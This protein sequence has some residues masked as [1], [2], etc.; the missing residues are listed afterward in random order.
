[1]GRALNGLV[2][3]CLGIGMLAATTAGAQ[4]FGAAKEKVTLERKLPALV[5][6]TGTTIKV[7]VTGHDDQSD[8]ARDL[9]A[10]LETEL[11]KDDPRLTA[12]DRNPSA[13]VTCQ[14]TNYSQP[15][16]TVTTRPSYG[17]SGGAQKSQAYTRVTGALSVSFQA[18]SAGGEMLGSDNVTVNYDQE[19]DSSGNATSQGVKGTVT[20]AWK[21]VVGGTNGEDFNPPTD[22]ELRSHLLDEAVRRIAEHIVN[23]SEMV[24]VY[25]ARQKGALD[26]G[27]K[28][29]EAGL[30]QRALETFETARPLSK[31]AEDA[32]RLYNIGVAYEALAYKAEDE[33]SAMKF[34]DEAA[35]NYG[36][37]IDAK[38]AEKY[39]REP[40]RRIET[41]IAH[42]K[43]L[44]DQENRKAE[45]A[46]AAA[47]SEKPPAAPPAAKAATA[48]KALSNAQVIAL[49]KSGVDDD[50]VAQ[51]IRAAKAVN[52]DLSA[53][54]QQDLTGNGVSAQVLAAMK[55]RAARKPAAAKPAAATPAAAK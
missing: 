10:L 25:L 53:G 50:T 13:V 29:A 4:N 19:F 21:R 43:K 27:D 28:E 14:I 12:E 24:E 5:R 55:S 8:L 23:T 36:K 1:M 33:K 44:E 6:L 2:T 7:K 3:S 39:F 52:F 54:G 37:A 48:A 15:Q 45:A 51:T 18:R 22:S 30:W 20:S 35:I 17:A 9:Q 34:L 42:Y 32:Y 40:Q 47:A 41:A 16:P 31:Q 11:L 38:P 26:E 46:T 49:V